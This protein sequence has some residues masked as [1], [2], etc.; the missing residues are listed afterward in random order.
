MRSRSP[1]LHVVPSRTRPGSVSRDGPSLDSVSTDHKSPVNAEEWV[2]VYF[3]KSPRAGRRGVC[4]H[5]RGRVVW[6][7]RYTYPDRVPIDVWEPPMPRV[8]DFLLNC[9]VYLYCSEQDAKDGSLYG[10]TGFLLGIPSES[11]PPFVHLY[12]VTNRH[13]VEGGACVL[14][15]NQRDGSTTILNLSA[16]WVFHPHGDDLAVHSI[17]LHPGERHSIAIIMTN[18]LLTQEFMNEQ[19]VGV[20]DETILAGRFVRHDGRMMNRPALRF[21]HIAMMPDPK[22]GVLVDIAGRDYYQEAFL[23]EG[24]TICGY[25]GSPV[26]WCRQHDADRSHVWPEYDLR[27]L[28]VH[29]HYLTVPEGSYA[30]AHGQSRTRTVEVPSGMMVVIPVWRLSEMLND[31]AL[32]AGRDEENRRWAKEKARWRGLF[33]RASQGLP[34]ATRRDR[35]RR[36]PSRASRGAL[37]LL[38]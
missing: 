19:D 33:S 21:G 15:A 12:V 5:G 35:R 10:G 24:R 1:W 7:T 37:V 17:A 36:P 25:S 18:Y 11:V 16:G 30:V 4:L 23:V 22:D 14:R 29:S 27:L 2:L 34:P 6:V 9:V 26:F 3:Q 13:L 38:C 32:V 31:P 8:P 28:G 20:G